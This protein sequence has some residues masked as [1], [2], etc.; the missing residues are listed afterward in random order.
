MTKKQLSILIASL[1]AATPLLAQTTDPFLS[2]G[3]VSAGGIVTDAN[4]KADREDFSKFNEYQDLTNGMLSTF[5]IQGRNSQ[6]WIN[7]YGENFG[8]DDMYVDLR[9]GMYDVF[10]AR[11]YTNWLPHNFLFNGLT[12]YVG[13]GGQT[14]SAAFPNPNSA[15]WQN[16]NLGYERKDTGGY[17]EWQQQS[18][19]Y[20]R[21]DG[22]QVKFSGT[23]PGSSSNTT[24]PGGGYSDLAMPQQYET[25]NAAFEVGYTTRTMTITASYL[26]S[27]FGNDFENIS[28]NNPAFGSNIDRTYLPPDNH[29][30]R[31]ALNGTWRALP[32]NSTLALRYTWDETK[33]DSNVGTQ[34][35]NAATGSVY[36]PTQPSTDTFNGDEKR[37]TFTA[38]WSATPIANLDTRAVLQ[39]AED[40]QRR[41]RR[42]VL[43][44]RGDLADAAPARNFFEN[45]LFHYE[46]QNAGVDAW[47]RFS[48]ANRLGF[49]YDWFNQKQDRF[50]FDDETT[51]TV[52]VEW[53]N[54]SLDTLMA[55]IKYSYLQRTADF[56]LSDAGANANDPAY[57]ERF[58]RAFDLTNLK[59][60]RSR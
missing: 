40:E 42:H 33:S 14:L 49:G 38:G 20:F 60:N 59:Q 47:W 12:P 19:W 51:N 26:A 53:K 8:R 30:Q 10:K 23:R 5:G 28:W 39:L 24:S 3:Q 36:L 32:W 25:N 41:H 55:R 7:A 13:S 22:N 43:P 27:N 46:K 54:T 52:W 1:F 2:T 50:D 4:S 6:S 37:Q 16:L 45:E 29:Y 57:L 34:V 44:E 58:V 21:V 35:L 48:R 17:F 56:L 15:N 31:F 11:A 9:G 18:P